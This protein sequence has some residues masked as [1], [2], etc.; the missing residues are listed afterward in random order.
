MELG[1][2]FNLSLNDLKK[3]DNNIFSYFCDYNVQW[4][5]YGRSAIRHIPLPTDK[6][7]LLP[8]FLCES[9]ILCFHKEQV[10]FYNIDRTFNI[11]EEDLFKKWDNS[12]GIVYICH[13]FGYLQNPKVLQKIRNYADERGCIVIEDTTQSLFSDHVTCGDYMVASI[14]KWMPIP[15]GGMLYTNRGEMPSLL[16]IPVNDDNFRTYG[17]ILK[18]L[19]LK[20]KYDTNA[21]YR[22]IFCR[23]EEKIDLS[24]DIKQ[25][26]Q[27]TKFL[28]ECVDINLLK[29]KR[30]QNYF[31]LQKELKKIELFPIRELAENEC[32]FVYPMRV[33]NRDKFRRYLMDNRIYCAVHWP[34][35][36]I[37]SKARVNARYNAETLLSLPIDQRYDFT[38][39]DY[40]IDVIKRY[41][42]ELL[43]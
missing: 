4:M 13:Y 19:F 27:F 36:N 33:N 41:G 6:M 42:G 31:R 16:D 15:Q 9:V 43:F 7:I 14:R 40:M 23:C 38:E 25:V 29:E 21:M 26:S 37:H 35:D 11:D 10:K 12:V 3:S 30:R 20:K 5:D 17:M 32:P 24:I 2:E 22:E 28:I 34:F 18:D 39:I 8:E 1:S